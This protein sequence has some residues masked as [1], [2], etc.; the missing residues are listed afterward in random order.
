MSK[1]EL[2]V[3]QDM[4]DSIGVVVEQLHCSMDNDNLKLCGSVTSIGEKIRGDKLHIKMNLCNE[5]GEIL[6]VDKTYNGMVLDKL[7]Y[8]SFS[9]YCFGLSK[10]V[11]ISALH[12]VE[13]FPC[14]V[15]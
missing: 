12:H 4:F 5:E 9:I 2:I 7:S 6:F 11:D 1:L 8:D 14:I 15:E 13:V 10:H 3:K